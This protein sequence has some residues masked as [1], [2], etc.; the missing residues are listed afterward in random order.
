M[1]TASTR[2]TPR[3]RLPGH[4]LDWKCN[5]TLFLPILLLFPSFFFFFLLLLFFRLLH[6]P[7]EKPRKKKASKQAGKSKQVSSYKPVQADTARKKQSCESQ[8]E[9]ERDSTLDPRPSTLPPSFCLA[10]FFAFFLPRLAFLVLFCLP[11]LAFA[12]SPWPTWRSQKER[13][14]QKK[15]RKEKKKKEKEK[16]KKGRR[17]LFL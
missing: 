5:L 8:R 1:L 11:C 13:K 17:T 7:E 3:R 2:L 9:R 16:K 10:F 4:G 15:K 6:K 14:K 12:I